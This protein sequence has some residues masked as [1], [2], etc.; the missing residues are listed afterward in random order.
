M[1]TIYAGVVLSDIFVIGYHLAADYYARDVS[2]NSDLINSVDYIM[3]QKNKAPNSC[4]L[5]FTKY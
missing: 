3:S 1:P 5:Y 4:P 2:R